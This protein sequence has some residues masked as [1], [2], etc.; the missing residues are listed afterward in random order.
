[1]IL[2][3][4]SDKELSI[5]KHVFLIEGTMQEKTQK[6]RGLGV[7]DEY[8][9]IYNEY[10]TVLKASDNETEKAEAL[11]RITFLSWHHMIEPSC[12]TGIWQL[13]SDAIHTAYQMVDNNLKHKKI[14][15]EFNWMLS[16]Y[17]ANRWTILMHSEKE[18]NTLST[19]VKNIDLTKLYLPTV[20]VLKT[21]MK[22]RG[23]MG[24]YFRTVS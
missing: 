18:M 23:Q 9:E 11:K 22:D 13:D 4:L 3:I 15:S 8:K 19:F 1:M 12:F 14:D 5:Y 24:E 20:D 6:L 16:Y 2:K 10:L 17:S 21:T 7:F